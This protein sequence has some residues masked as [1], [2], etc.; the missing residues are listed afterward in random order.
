[1][2]DQNIFESEIES[3]SFSA[4]YMEFNPKYTIGLYYYNPCQTKRAANLKLTKL[5]T[6]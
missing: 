3:N 4:I 1:M 6:G 5:N 2:S